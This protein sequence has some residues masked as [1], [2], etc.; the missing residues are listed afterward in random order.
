[1]IFPG[2]FIFIP[3]LLVQRKYVMQMMRN[4]GLEIEVL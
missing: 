1:M 2:V 4:T 3:T